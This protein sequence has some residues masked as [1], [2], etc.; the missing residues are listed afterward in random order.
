MGPLLPVFQKVEGRWMEG[1]KGRLSLLK[2]KVHKKK[3]Y[4]RASSLPT[5]GCEEM[6]T[7]ERK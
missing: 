1:G 4:P 2:K 5:G 7:K 3:K 6:R